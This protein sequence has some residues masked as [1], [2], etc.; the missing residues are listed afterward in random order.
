MV[1]TF[2]SP[3]ELTFT[4]WGCCGFRFWYK[5]TELAHSFLFSSGVW[6]IFMAL[7]TAFHSI[8]SPDSTPLSH[9]VF[10]VLFLPYWSFQLYPSLVKVSLSH[11]LQWEAADAEIKVPP[12]ENKELKR[13]PFKAW[14]RSVYSHTCYAYCQEFLP[15]LFLTFQSIHLHFFQIP[16][17]FFHALA[18]AYT[19]SCVGLQNKI[20]HPARRRFPCWVPTEYE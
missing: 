13:S 14:S 19:G 2:E 12:G 7:S 17:R 10:P 4:W 15:C 1:C 5:P 20:G 6:S 9:S 18:V 11:A 16:S 8:N 3:H